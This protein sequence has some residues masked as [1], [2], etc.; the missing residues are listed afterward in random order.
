MCACD[1]GVV[2]LRYILVPALFYLLVLH[3]IHVF[4][5]QIR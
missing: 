1:V 2:A 5:L 4:Y 3:V